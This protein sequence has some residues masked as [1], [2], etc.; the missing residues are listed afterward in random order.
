MSF[1]LARTPPGDA[2]AVMMAEEQLRV[3]Y[4]AWRRTLHKAKDYRVKVL[5]VLA[6]DGNGEAAGLLN[7]PARAYKAE[8]CGECAG[9]QLMIR[10]KAC[11]ECH[12]CKNGKGCEEHHRRCSEWPRIANTFHAG[13][14][15]TSVS[16]Q[17]DILTAD[18]SKYEAAL[19]ALREIDL[20]MEED[21]DQL[22][23]GSTSRMNPRFSPAGRTRELE[24]ERN[25]LA[26]L[27]VLLQ[28]HGEL[29]T[30]LQEVADD[31]DEPQ[32]VAATEDG[33]DVNPL[34]GTQTSRELIRMFGFGAEQNTGTGSGRGTWNNGE[35]RLST[36]E[37]ASTSPGGLSGG[38]WSLD[39]R[40]ASP[41]LLRPLVSDEVVRSP[42]RIVA[43]TNDSAPTPPVDTTNVPRFPGAAVLRPRLPGALQARAGTLPGAQL[44]VFP[45]RPAVAQ[46]TGFRVPGVA[47]QPRTA[48]EA[49]NERRRSQSNEGLSRVNTAAETK[50]RLE[51]R[52]FEL[53][54]WIQTRRNLIAT[55][56]IAIEEAIVRAGRP[57][58][59]SPQWINE[60]LQFVLRTLED[61]EKSEMEVW[62]LVARLDSQ[63]AR[64]TRAQEWSHWFQQ[65]MSKAGT[66][67]ESLSKPAEATVAAPSKD[68][69]RCQRSGGFLERVR[70]PQFSGSVEDYGEFKGQFQELCRGESYTSVI[71]LAQL[72]QK[73]PKDAVALLV[74]LVS[75]EAAW[76][77]LDETYGNEDLQVFAA[78]KRLRAFKPS[79]TAVQG[80]VVELAIAVQRC[81]TVLRALSREQDFLV[82]RETLAEVIDALPTDSQ[83]RWYHRRGARNE[84]LQE[85][86]ANFLL[87]LEE[88]RA[89]AVA[90]HLDSLARR[91]KNPGSQATAP[92]VAAS[93]GG[94]TDQSVF[95]AT[96]TERP[97]QGSSATPALADPTTALTQGSGASAKTK[98]PARVEV[99]TIAQ[100]REVAAKR[101]ANLEAKQLDKCPICKTQHEYEKEWSQI[102]P[103]TKIKMVSTLLTSCPQFL[104]Q[105]PAQK[106]VT[107]TAHAACPLC[108]S[109]EHTKHKFGGRELPEPKCK[110]DVAGSECGGPHGKWYHATSGN[111]GNLVS[112][113]LVTE[114]SPTPGLFE[115]YSADFVAQDGSRIVGTIMIHSGSDT[116][117]VRHNFARDLGLEG[118]PH[119][120]RI[121]VVD[122]DYRTVDTAKYSLTVVDVD[123]ETHVVAAQGLGS[124][125]TLQPDPDLSPLLPLLDG[126]LERV[127]ARPQGRV[128]VLIGLHNSKLHGKDV[129]EWGN[130]RLLKSRFGC[131]WALRGTHELLQF[132]SK[133]SAPSYSMELHAV[134]NSSEEVPDGSQVFHV[135]TSHGRA[136]EFHEL[137]EL[138]TTPKPAC[139]RC[140]GC[141]ECTFRRKKLSRE[142]QEVV[143]RIEASLQVDEVTGVMSGTYPWKP[144]VG[145]MRSN[146]GQAEKIQAS[147]ERHMLSAG[148]HADFV[149]EVQK[150][151]EDGR[152][153]RLTEDEM[154]RWHGPV[155]Y[156]TIFAVVKLESL[157]TKTRVVSNSALKNAVS[158]LSLNDCLWP[159]PN[160]L[161]DLLDCLIFWR[162]VEVAIIMDL[163]KAY[164]AIHTSPMELHLRRFLFRASPDQAWETFGY[165]R[166][167]FG[168]LSAGL[169]LEVGKRRVANLGEGIDPQAAEQLK[170]KSYVDDSILGGSPEDVA[171]MR[172]E[173]TDAGYTGTVARILSKG[174]MSIKFMAVT[175][176][177]D[178]HEKEQL[179]G[180]CLGVG[181]RVTEDQLH[182][183][184]DPCFYEY[185]AKS[186]DQAREVT[187]LSSREVAA[188]QA[189]T[190]KFTR[191]QALSMVMAL[192]DPLG[193][194]GPT[195]V[196]GKLLLCRLYSP[197]HVTSWDQ[198]L[199]AT[200]KQ[201]W[202][203]WFTTL[204]SSQEATFPRTTR[205]KHAAGGPRLV[206]F[207]DSS[208]VAVCASLYVVWSTGSAGATVRLLMGKCR[209]APLLGMTVPRGEMQS[210]TILTR[211][212]VV[213]AEAFPAR[214]LSIS[215]YTDSMCSIGALSKTS[216]TL[217]PYF[218]NRVSEDPASKGP[219]RRAY[220][221][222]R[223]SAP[224]SGQQQSRR[225]GDKRRSAS[226]GAV[227]GFSVAV[228]AILPEQTVRELAHHNGRSSPRGQGSGG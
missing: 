19:E 174:A 11:G 67:C 172:G 26:R 47:S 42:E 118:E 64:R 77:R 193:L 168:D 202:A 91:P 175:G 136:A 109:W 34:T 5:H 143:S 29:A 165:T 87:W 116:D 153:R 209:V 196:T 151:I 3:H 102:T 23:P 152:V 105:P 20:E 38:G 85:K 63:E 70:L 112:A 208:E 120:C 32:V 167:N 183:R 169:M 66:I 158:R 226:G 115:V 154:T 156:V 134:R 40:L 72:R 123:G 140:S 133:C 135:V 103:P 141:A 54:S 166:A 52:R 138:G 76:A 122:M 176:S 130:L 131:G 207:C 177:D 161:A 203:S 15:V 22:A 111:T 137:A 144:C 35:D 97:G 190:L 173:R 74:G 79:K 51:D 53:V 199:P 37:E 195:L 96:L 89:D 82:D 121:K 7:E 178:S 93:Q 24:D 185:K 217:K 119:V 145:R 189:G 94:G 101:K 194:V 92:K 99:T 198:D 71:E 30:R 148:T 25:H 170:T 225:F 110:V 88:E 49:R 80:Q 149:E 197:S 187:R 227:G 84:T 83:Q 108:T 61:T 9:C 128:D 219:A 132:P 33:G 41:T 163:K 46:P 56:L 1:S 81:L 184:L 73:L 164:Q 98:A 216:T 150:S 75:P 39:D 106:L 55:R 160:A 147:V 213:A 162:G 127:L 212:M 6:G 12:G 200:E 8:R 126:I 14:V 228:W 215:S 95:V 159:G 224:C 114:T 68:T 86:G 28:R 146:R 186:A 210:L 171:R 113:P 142:D 62:K 69:G 180:K 192:Y 223:S 13:S 206:G 58:T 4:R 2:P 17:F 182:F 10:E 44:P 222:P 45:P 48:S 27:A 31:E 214:F 218:G 57:G 129:R 139:E 188:L 124:I 107:V 211:L 60:E 100:A 104:A 179:G 205:P 201:K 125:T 191:R 117:Y 59:L 90:I 43:A 65:V 16:S 18:L 157:S 36:V 204:L 21:M 221:R 155:H 181:Y 220:R 78:I 50:A